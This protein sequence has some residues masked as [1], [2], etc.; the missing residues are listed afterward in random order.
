MTTRA[1]AAKELKHVFVF[2]GTPSTAESLYEW[3]RFEV[4]GKLKVWLFERPR[5]G[6]CGRSS[7]FCSWVEIVQ[8]HLEENS[9]SEFSIIAIS[10]GGPFGL[11]AASLDGCLELKLISSVGDISRYLDSPVLSDRIREMFILASMNDRGGLA[12][13]LSRNLNR[14]H[15]HPS[16]FRNGFEVIADELIQV[17]SDWGL[18]F[19]NIKCPV[20]AHHAGDDDVSPYDCVVALGRNLSGFSIMKYSGGHRFF[21]DSDIMKSLIRS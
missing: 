2:G 1:S 20:I 16:V 6:V 17:W 7:D 18:N 19:C 15:F 13:S 11:A 5:Y 14:E 10:G 4:P 8:A 9:I 21:K 12:D 3:K